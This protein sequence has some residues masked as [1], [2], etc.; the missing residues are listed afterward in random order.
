MT[1]AFAIVVIAVAVV[2]VAGAIA[3]LLLG[4]RGWEG[5][6]ADALLKDSDAGDR[7]RDPIAAGG[8]PGE[9]EDEVRQLLQARN[10]RRRRRGEPPLDVEAELAR[11]TAPASPTPGPE[12]GERVDPALREEIRGLVLARNARRQRRGQPPLDVEAEIARQIADLNL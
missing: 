7:R 8:P 9:R 2:G 4:R 10:A 6:G 3:A 1:H 5:Y 12:D 11:L